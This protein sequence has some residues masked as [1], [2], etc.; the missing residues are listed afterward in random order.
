MIDEII[1]SKNRIEALTD[2]IFAVVMT[3]LVLDISVP[4]I[5]S[6]HSIVGSTV[7]R[8]ELLKRLFDLWQKILSFG[9]SFTILAI[10]W[11]AHHRQFHY[12]KHSNSALIW[13][14][15]VFLMAT[16]LLPFSTSLLGEYMDQEISILIYGSNSIVIASLLYIQWWYATA[17]RNGRLV[18]ENLDP[19]IKT[20]SSRR[21]LFGIIVY[22]IAIGISFVYIQL[23]VFLFAIII[24]PAFLPNKLMHYVFFIA[25]FIISF[26]IVVLT[27]IVIYT[28]ST[29]Y[30]TAEP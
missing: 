1:L 10:Y 3:I 20:T 25:S 17:S 27:S 9:I 6:S 30:K 24:V 11:M 22:L 4:Q 14:N 21:L 8:N 16:C 2:G 5:S 28:T 12:I 13:I 23:S 29:G 7:A 18:D 26:V 15:I 19:I